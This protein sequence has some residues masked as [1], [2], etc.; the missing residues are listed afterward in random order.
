MNHEIDRTIDID[1]LA[2]K[3][4][5]GMSLEQLRERQGGKL[6]SGSIPPLS[7][8]VPLTERGRRHLESLSK[9]TEQR[10]PVLRDNSQQM[11]WEVARRKV[12]A[13][14]EMRAAHIS[15]IEDKDFNW[16]FDEKNL[17]IIRNLIRYFI[18][19]KEC[20]WPLQKGL[21]MY[22]MP[23]TG[24]TEMMM[25]FERFCEEN[26]L[27]KRFQ[28]T[29]MAETYVRAKADKQFDPITWNI[30]LDRCFDEF[31]LYTGA[32]TTFGE[33]LDINEAI[34]EARYKRFRHGGQ[35]S[36]FISNATPNEMKGKLTPMAF[37]R[38][39]QMCVSVYF[40]GQS[41]RK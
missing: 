1:A 25:I 24:K 14:F 21:F 3:L 15:Q 6:S 30:Q 27:A 34:I 11:K 37:D 8:A 19:D 35:L 13:L 12:W 32:V 26:E 2:K 4:A 38:I 16:E 9:D 23:G 17:G 40:E 18:N 33:S 29:S 36:H 22:G 7:P 5:N 20:A 28:F 10:Q 39:Q 31:G 41:K